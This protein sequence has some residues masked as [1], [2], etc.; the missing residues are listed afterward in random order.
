MSHAQARL[1]WAALQGLFWSFAKNWGGR[2]LAVTSFAILARFLDPEAFGIVAAASLIFVFIGMVAEFGFGDA[3]VQS[4]SLDPDDANLPFIASMT[5]SVILAALAA[6][7]SDAIERYLSVPGLHRVIV[8]MC[9]LAPL[10]TAS[11][12][13]EAWF[14][15]SLQF[16]PLAARVFVSHLVAGPLAVVCAVSGAGVWT[17]V[18]NAYFAAIVGVLWLWRGAL[19]TPG[20]TL[21]HESFRSL[22][23]FGVSVVS[24]RLLE[25]ALVRFVDF[26]IATRFGIASLGLYAVATRIQKSLMALLQSSINDAALPVLSRMSRDRD[27]MGRAYMQATVF[28][29]YLASPLFVLASA[30]IPAGCDLVLGAK[31]DGVAV[32]ARPLLLLASLQCVQFL[33]G[34]YLSSR[35]HPDRVLL[36]ATV[37]SLTTLIGLLMIP[38]STLAELMKVFAIAQALSAPVSFFMVTR[39]LGIPFLRLITTL[40]PAFLACLVAYGSLPLARGGLAHSGLPALVVEAILG[41]AFLTC[42]AVCVFVF[43]RVQLRTLFD[44]I[45]D[46]FGGRRGMLRDLLRALVPLPVRQIRSRALAWIETLWLVASWFRFRRRHIEASIRPDPGKVLIL[47]SDPRTLAGSLGDEAILLS[48]VRTGARLAPPVRFQVLVT[49]SEADAHARRLGLDPVQVSG[50]VKD[51]SAVRT[52]LSTHGFGAVVAMGADVVDGSY[53]V[54]YATKMLLTLD[55]AARMG[56]PATVLSFSFARKPSWLQRQVWSGLDPR[57]QLNLRDEVSLRR[58]EASTGRVGQ[59]VADV[60]FLLEPS[61]PDP[62]AADW[63]ASQRQ[64]GRTVLGLNLHPGLMDRSAGAGFDA[65]VLSLGETLAEIAVAEKVAWLLIVHDRRRNTGDGALLGPLFQ[66]LTRRIEDRVHYLGGEGTSDS[67][68]GLLGH[69]DGLVSGRMHLAIGGL[70]MGVPVLAIVYQGKFEGLYRHFRLPGDLLV[71]PIHLTDPLAMRR[72]ILSF[73]GR[74]ADIGRQITETLPGVREQAR[75]N[76]AGWMSGLPR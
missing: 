51:L 64:A 10:S 59:F 41:V 57:I 55:V 12:Y 26:L 14:K 35:G 22:A 73:I 9:G 15:R 70:G 29:A 58:F 38:A 6:Y 42:Y 74:L 72:A 23:R 7:F 5:A 67:V 1:D 31:W 20:W 49:G 28:V 45:G 13:Q 18:G 24:L 46:R 69:L 54:P 60:A 3:I 65:A 37:K 16:R 75:R 40:S 25:F 21:R 66:D 47:P 19:W 71:D 32:L 2:F 44:F 8:A 39:D 11:L 76:L 36:V 4:R 30:L 68:K 48:V 63:I 27:R 53:S 52:L 56:L 43:G 17:L 62:E 34:P 50:G 33:N 61:A